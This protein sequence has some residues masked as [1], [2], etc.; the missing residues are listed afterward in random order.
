M[1]L[2]IVLFIFSVTP[3]YGQTLPKKA[4]KIDDIIKEFRGAFELKISE[5]QRNYITHKNG[6]NASFKSHE[7]TQCG[8]QSA[9]AGDSL[10][11]IQM[12]IHRDDSSLTESIFYTGCAGQ[13]NLKEIVVTNGSDLNPISERELFEGKRK[14][15]LLAN[16]QSRYYSLRAW[17]DQEIFRL[18]LRRLNN[19]KVAE[20]FIRGQR[21]MNMTIAIEEGT[22]RVSYTL[23]PYTFKYIRP[24]Q[25]WSVNRSLPTHTLTAV[26][27][28]NGAS[29]DQYFNSTYKEIS[30]SSFQSYFSYSVLESSLARISTYIK[31]HL[32]VFPSTEFTSSGAQSSRF[33]DELRLTFTRLLSNTDINLV[34]NLIQSYIL[35]IEEG[36][37][38]IID[39]RP[40]E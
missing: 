34:R 6:R 21:F 13:L 26:R 5:L 24:D 40:T 27:N 15:D 8:W 23:Y 25:S 10:A 39:S 38:K 3:L 12:S 1:R 32:F 2:L 7:D 30:S 37:I 35:A 33:L 22:T 20:F 14:F 18:T 31:W 28:T 29:K 4:F 17:D 11:K 36:V 19:G 16:E 9:Q